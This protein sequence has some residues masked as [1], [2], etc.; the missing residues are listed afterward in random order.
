MSFKIPE[1][2][3]R[4][5]TVKTMA[6]R[7]SQDRVTRIPLKFGSKLGYFG[8]VTSSCSTCGTRSVNLVTNLVVSHE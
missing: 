1:A 3:N 4:R 5:M 6:N 2:V 7:K 8:R